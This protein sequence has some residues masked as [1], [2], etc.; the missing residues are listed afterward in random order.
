MCD[1]VIHVVFLLICL[2]I[3]DYVLVWYDFLQSDMAR[4]NKTC[5]RLFK[6]YRITCLKELVRICVKECINVCANR[7][8]ER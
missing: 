8:L 2:I 5:V 3:L 1:S 4:T 6:Y 7:V